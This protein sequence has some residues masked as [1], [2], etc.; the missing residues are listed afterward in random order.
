EGPLR[1]RC[2][3]SSAR[4]LEAVIVNTGGGVAGG[5]SLQLHLSV[6]ENARL[7]V[8]TAAAEKIYRSLGAD[9][10]IDVRLKVE[11]GA[12][13]AWLPHETILFDHS[14]LRRTIRIDVAKDAQLVFTEAVV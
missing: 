3:N 8:T 1:L 14:R 5:D 9:A 6:D 4:A 13:L 2:P 12:A 7:T 11:S 10:I